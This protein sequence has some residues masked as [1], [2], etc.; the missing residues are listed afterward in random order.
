MCIRDS[1]YAAGRNSSGYIALPDGKAYYDYAI[2]LYT[3]TTLSAD[4][5]HQ[6]GLS[7]VVRIES[8]WKR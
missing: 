2:K 4:S 5:I 8:E 6:L 1:Y 7:E 3:T